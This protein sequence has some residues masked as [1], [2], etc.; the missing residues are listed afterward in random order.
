MLHNALTQ[1]KDGSINPEPT[2]VD[3]LKTFAVA[4]ACE[5]SSK[6]NKPVKMTDF[7]DRHNVP[8]EWR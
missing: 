2:G 7:Y 4:A 8:E 5:E 3:H 6:T 1:I